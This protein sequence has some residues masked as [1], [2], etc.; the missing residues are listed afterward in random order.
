MIKNEHEE[1][2]IEALIDEVVALY[3]LLRGVTARVHS[4]TGLTAAKRGVLRSLNRLGPQTV[5]QMARARPVSRQHIQTIV[6]QLHK[7]E[8]VQLVP[9]PAHKRSRLVKLTSRGK[10]VITAAI[11]KEKRFLSGLRLDLN[12]NELRV[13]A[14]VLQKIRKRFESIDWN[15]YLGEAANY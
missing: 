3:H 7:E 1:P 14:S 6:N 4:D 11:R 13:T 10:K 2:T 12:E 9:N 8:F 15:E 5:P